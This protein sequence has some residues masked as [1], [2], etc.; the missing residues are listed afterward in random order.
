MKDLKEANVVAWNVL[1]KN[2]DIDLLRKQIHYLSELLTED[3]YFQGSPLSGP[4]S[5]HDGLEGVLNLLEN[6]YDSAME[7]KS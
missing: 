7:D 4:N 6:M 1:V 5:P 2:V 3:N